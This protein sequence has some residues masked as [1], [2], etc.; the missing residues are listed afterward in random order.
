MNR[1]EKIFSELRREGRKAIMPFLTAGDPD[2]PTTGQL[3]KAME[4]AGASVC[5]LGFPFSDPIADGPVIQASMSWALEHGVRMQAILEMVA[6]RRAELKIGVVAMVSYSIVHR[7]G[8]GVFVREAARAG[9]DGLIVPDLTLE[10]SDDLRKLAAEH[11]LT[12]SLLVAPRTPPQRA[13]Q[14]ARACTGFVYVLARAGLTGEREKLPADL[15]ERIRQLRQETDLPIA[16]GFGISRAEHVAEVVRHA[17]AAIVGSAIMRRIGALRE[18]SR[19][20]LIA[21]VENFVRGLA[22]G[23]TAQRAEAAKGKR[24]P[25]GSGHEG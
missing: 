7:W 25:T 2:L 21:E 19:E 20:K 16:V 8:D 13:A 23:L 4:R 5:E 18:E 17:D 22:E 24:G 3:L 10:E 15:A 1:I 6:Q 11:G 9:I 12:C 14:I